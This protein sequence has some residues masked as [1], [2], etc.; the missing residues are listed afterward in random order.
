VTDHNTIQF[1]EAAG[2]NDAGLYPGAAPPTRPRINTIIRDNLSHHNANGLSGTMGSNIR[3]VDNEFRD[4][5]NGMSLDSLG[6]DGHPGFPQNSTI[7]EHNRIHSNN[8]DTYSDKAWVHSTVQVPIGDGIIVGG[9]NDNRIRSNYIYDNWKRGTMVLSVPD[10]ITRDP[11][12]VPDDLN[13][14]TSHRNQHEGNIMGIAPD[15]TEKPN[16]VDFWWDEFGQGNCW[17]SNRGPGPGGSVTS[18]PSHLPDCDDFPNQG[19][20]NQAKQAILVNCGGIGERY[21]DKPA[22]DWFRVPPKPKPR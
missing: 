5:S 21:P 19:T 8:F 10:A 2:S 3:I 9:G 16:G 15:G 7:I 13:F 17:E 11:P 22:C 1:T 18:D 20:G 4:N 6:Q 12:K 14:S